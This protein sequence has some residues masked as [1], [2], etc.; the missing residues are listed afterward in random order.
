MRYSASQLFDAILND[1]SLALKML[2]TI[3]DINAVRDHNGE[4]I[5]HYLAHQS[6]KRVIDHLLLSDYGIDVKALINRRN[7]YG[8]TPITLA[9]KYTKG[10]Y[11]ENKFI[12]FLI[13]HGADIT[14]PNNNGQAFLHFKPHYIFKL[15]AKKTNI[16]D[17]LKKL[18]NLERFYANYKHAIV[19]AKIYE[20]KAYLYSKQ[21]KHVE[22]AQSYAEAIKSLNDARSIGATSSLSVRDKLILQTGK[23]AASTV[24]FINQHRKRKQDLLA[25]GPLYRLT[26]STEANFPWEILASKVYVEDK[27][28]SEVFRTEIIRIYYKNDHLKS[29][30]EALALSV[31]SNN[32]LKWFLDRGTKVITT[33]KSSSGNVAIVGQYNGLNKIVIASK[34][35]SEHKEQ[36]SISLA[37]GTFVHE[38]THLL[39]K[40]LFGNYNPY[41]CNEQAKQK[42]F[43]K[44]VRDCLKRI[45]GILGNGFDEKDIE[46]KPTYEIGQ[47]LQETPIPSDLS[48]EMR[49]VIDKMLYIYS[50]KSCY[51]TSNEHEEIIARWAQLTAEGLSA[52]AMEI[53]SPIAAYYEEH[54]KPVKE[55]FINKHRFIHLIKRQQQA[56]PVFGEYT[57]MVSDKRKMEIAD[58]DLLN[59]KRYKQT[60]LE[61]C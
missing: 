28:Q 8:N 16:E 37:F 21:F 52:Q 44:A 47:I 4:N 24:G 36:D 10:L 33:K 53:I 22:A 60:S 25:T 40:I 1:R 45:S 13:A 56:K 38:N 29:D 35:D 61:Y 18:S 57:Q 42:A 54:I 23:E 3:K 12:D 43:S 20:A 51:K 7:I 39:M 50:S 17:N 46:N 9:A 41:P 58:N 5:L 59:I 31:I 32:K 27:D 48:W 49:R 34:P 26:S 55:E 11:T 2:R 19:K 30:M 15:Y 14:I 6:T